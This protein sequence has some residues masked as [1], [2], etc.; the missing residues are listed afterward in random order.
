M[1]FN[2]WKLQGMR[3]Q[4]LNRILLFVPRIILHFPIFFGQKN[5]YNT[6][7]SIWLKEIWC[8]FHKSKRHCLLFNGST[9][10]QI[11]LLLQMDAIRHSEMHEP[12]TERF[13]I[14][15]WDIDSHQTWISQKKKFLSKAFQMHF[16]LNPQKLLLFRYSR[17]IKLSMASD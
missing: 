1:I 9:L 13:L 11:V 15:V 14:S 5:I 4:F 3:I 2:K 17:V 7:L 12:G 16:H 10:I 8:F 6:I